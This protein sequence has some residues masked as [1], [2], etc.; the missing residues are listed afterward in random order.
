M[1]TAMSMADIAAIVVSAAPGDMEVGVESGAIKETILTC[2]TMGVKNVVV[3]VTK[4]DE[5]SIQYSQAKFDEIKK[6]VSGYL[7]EVGYKQKDPPFVP[8]SGI[9]G[10]NLA[11]KSCE[12]EWYAGASVVGALDA[13]GASVNRPDEKPLRIPVLKV[14]DVKGVGVTITGRVE[15]GNVRVG[16]KLIFSPGGKTAEVKSIHVGGSDVREGSSGDIV[17]LALQVLFTSDQLHRGMVASSVSDDPAVAVDS[18][19][20]QVVMLDCPGVIREGYCPS[21]SIHTAQVQ[22]EFEEFLSKIDRKTGK[23]ETEKPVTA[24]TGEVI[25]ARL[26]PRS[27]VCVET[28]ATFPSL[29]R[30]A[31]RDHNRTIAVG[32]V[33]EVTKRPVPKIRCLDDDE[34]EDG[35]S[36]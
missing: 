36:D 34:G 8:V 7:K 22:C 19:V 25:T 23:E 32:V 29:G 18:L 27:N 15:T 17:S 35:D 16:N 5:F 11:E 4:M 20:A 28:F 1:I 26:R 31:V 13:L 30:F 14:S 2:F 6:T 10:D 12:T 3:L 21:I 24:K 9:S 33:K